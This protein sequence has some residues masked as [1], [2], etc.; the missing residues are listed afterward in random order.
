[1]NRFD[2]ARDS[3]TNAMNDLKTKLE[4]DEA[5]DDWIGAHILMREAETLIPAAVYGGKPD[6][7]SAPSKP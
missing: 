3:F 4:L 6:T 5:W 7:N 2:D 1:L